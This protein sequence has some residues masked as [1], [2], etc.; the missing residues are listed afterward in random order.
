M[1]IAIPVE[2]CYISLIERSIEVI[3]ISDLNKADVLAA[4]YNAAKP[5]GMGFLQYDPQPMTQAEA[6][7][8]LH[9]TTDFDYLKGRVMK[10]SLSGGEFDP[11]LYDRDNGHGAAQRAI[12]ALVASNNTNGPCIQ[13]AHR[14]NTAAAARNAK[15]Q[16]GDASRVTFEEGIPACH[17]GLGDAA[18]HLAPVLDEVLKDDPEIL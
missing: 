15:S 9:E 12:D 4:L 11:R 14:S 7:Q 5:Q 17:I 3:K 16:L 13:D 18:E 2:P 6:A 10:I 1:S 8:I